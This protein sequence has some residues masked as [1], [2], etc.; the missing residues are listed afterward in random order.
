VQ[1]RV[2]TDLLCMFLFDTNEV[3]VAAELEAVPPS[4]YRTRVNVS[5]LVWLQL[6]VSNSSVFKIKTLLY[7][8]S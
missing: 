3:E 4:L 2:A 7:L 5:S 8:T 6:Q 1:S